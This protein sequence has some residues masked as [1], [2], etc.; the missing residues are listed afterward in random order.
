MARSVARLIHVMSAAAGCCNYLERNILAFAGIGPIRASL[1]GSI[2]AENGVRR[3][4]WL[5]R[6]AALGPV[7]R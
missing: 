1:I 4:R 3:E 6:M 2:E 5:A 7:G